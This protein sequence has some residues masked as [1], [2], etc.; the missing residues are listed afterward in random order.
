[1]DELTIPNLPLRERVETYV[2]RKE[3]QHQAEEP[4]RLPIE[5]RKWPRRSYGPGQETD[6]VVLYC[7]LYDEDG[8]LG[9]PGGGVDEGETLTEAACREW[10]EETGFAAKNAVSLKI[11]AFTYY[12]NPPYVT[13]A[14]VQRATR[15]C[16]SRTHY[17]T[18]VYAHEPPSATKDPSNLNELDWYS[19]T[20]VL[21]HFDWW[22]RDQLTLSDVYQINVACYRRVEQRRKAV[23]ASFV[24]FLNGGV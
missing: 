18:A 12:W 24:H 15:Y 1:M 4:N 20:E 23:T 7:G 17:V 2:M 11:P 13:P 8:S 10:Q 5:D 19:I 6:S 16:G 21:M 14:Q 3:H 22:L 9:V